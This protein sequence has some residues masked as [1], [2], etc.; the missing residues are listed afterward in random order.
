[1]SKPKIIFSN[2]YQDK[3][4]SISRTAQAGFNSGDFEDMYFPLPPIN[5]QERIVKKIS[6]LWGLIDAITAEL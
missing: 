2:I 1:M 4:K 6:S 3:L 5:E